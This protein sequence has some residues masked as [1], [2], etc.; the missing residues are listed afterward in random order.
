[1]KVGGKKAISCSFLDPPEKSSPCFFTP[2]IKENPC[3]LRQLI[4][5]NQYNYNCTSSETIVIK[6]KI[7]LQHMHH[8]EHDSDCLV[9][10]RAGP[11]E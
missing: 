9:V 2:Q 3:F 6:E 5:I 1:M 7:V 10:K 4:K 11:L 8:F